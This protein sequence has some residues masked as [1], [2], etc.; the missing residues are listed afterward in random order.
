MRSVLW[1]IRSTAG[2]WFLVQELLSGLL[3]R[4]PPVDLGPFPVGLAVPSFDFPLQR[5]QVRNPPA[6]QT[7]PGDQTEFDFRLIEP[8]PVLRS[9]MDGGRSQT[10]PPFSSPK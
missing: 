8:T 1:V 6:S 2:P 3:A 10:E 5:L 7:L 9:V 4:E